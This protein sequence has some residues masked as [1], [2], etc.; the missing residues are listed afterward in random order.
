MQC[1]FQLMCAG[2][3]QE[4]VA[5]NGTCPTCRGNIRAADGIKQVFDE[6]DVQAPMN[7]SFAPRSFLDMRTLAWFKRILMVLCPSAR[8]IVYIDFPQS[9]R[10]QNGIEIEDFMSVEGSI[11]H[12]RRLCGNRYQIKNAVEIFN[13]TDRH[14]GERKGIVLSKYMM[15]HGCSLHKATDL[16]I[17]SQSS[18]AAYRHLLSRAMNPKRPL[19]DSDDE[20]RLRVHVLHTPGNF[21]PDLSLGVAGG[22][23]TGGGERAHIYRRLIVT[24]GRVSTAR[25]L[26]MCGNHG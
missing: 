26:G 1:C 7:I 10:Y 6:V 21:V 11:Y 18:T 20:D 2:C 8:V 24:V 14:P 4:V 22:I 25:L 9:F 12:T 3:L 23:G 16:V 19:I 17:L 13:S 15:G 5:I